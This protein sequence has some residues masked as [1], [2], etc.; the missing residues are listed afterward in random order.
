VAVGWLGPAGRRKVQGRRVL[1]RTAQTS[2][3]D[4]EEP[5]TRSPAAGSA[6]WPVMARRRISL[7]AAR[8]RMERCAS[9]VEKRKRARQGSASALVGGR[10]GEG[11]LAG[12]VA[13]IN[14][15]EGLRPSMPSRGGS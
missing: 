13:A 5:R 7:A 15:H 3:E 4:E 1:V 2:V 10:E 12:E 14:G 8:A 9:G 11:A 6:G